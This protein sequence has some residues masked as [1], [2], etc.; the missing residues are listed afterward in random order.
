MIFHE[1]HN[2]QEFHARRVKISKFTTLFQKL[3]SGLW[4]TKNHFRN[5]FRHVGTRPRLFT[6]IFKKII[7]SSF[8]MIF[9]CMLPHQC[10]D[11]EGMDRR[12]SPFFRNKSA[13]NF[14]SIVLGVKP[15]QHGLG[16][17]QSYFQ[18]N[19]HVNSTHNFYGAQTE[20]FFFHVFLLCQIIKGS[21]NKL[22]RH[23]NYGWQTTAPRP[24]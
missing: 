13:S 5:Y 19:F 17:T 10:K 23:P 20:S 22:S 1:N 21:S 14:F 7:F 15:F 8:F 2:F 24:L 16:I 9:R 12:K 11:G 4:S 6:T 3:Q 18:L